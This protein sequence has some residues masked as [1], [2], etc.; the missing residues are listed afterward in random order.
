MD[1]TKKLKAYKKKLKLF[2]LKTRDKTK[3]ILK[4]CIEHKIY[5][6]SIAYMA[7]ISP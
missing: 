6:T 1:K 3:K 5:L 4:K 2:N 7:G